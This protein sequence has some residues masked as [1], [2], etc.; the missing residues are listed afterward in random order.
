MVGGG[1]IIG[2][3]LNEGRERNARVGGQA[4]G[5]GWREVVREGGSHR[6]SVREEI[7]RWREKRREGGIMG[8]GGMD[9][10]EI[11]PPKIEL[12]R[13]GGNEGGNE[14]GR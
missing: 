2:S 5:D 3:N 13:E 9:L 8:E 7:D 6:G 14:G 10:G 1:R 12:T 4:Q 11:L